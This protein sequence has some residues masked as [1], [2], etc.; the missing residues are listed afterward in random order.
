MTWQPPVLA[1]AAIFIFWLARKW[2]SQTQTGF[3]I[4]LALLGFF[5]T[6]AE[7]QLFENTLKANQTLKP[8]G[9]A[10]RDNFQP[11]DAVV[12]WG[13]LPEGLPF[14]SGGAISAKNLPFLGGMDLTQVPFEFPGNRERL[15][16]IFLPDE[17][18]LAELL[19]SGKRVLIVSSGNAVEK[20]QQ[21]N[22]GISLHLIFR[23]GQ[24]EMFSNR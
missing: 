21:N 4:I 7:I 13:K 17:N 19:Q 24:W 5:A 16:K 1:V 10:L 11:G 23:S 9:I 2:K 12:C 15:G 20:I 18:A 6:L 3:T 22:S 8:L 14:Y